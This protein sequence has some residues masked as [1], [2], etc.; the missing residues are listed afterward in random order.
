LGGAPTIS[1]EL[2]GVSTFHSVEA[3]HYLRHSRLGESSAY[4]ATCNYY[5]CKVINVNKG[6]NVTQHVNDACRCGYFEIGS[7]QLTRTYREGRI[8][9]LTMTLKKGACGCSDSCLKDLA[10]S[11]ISVRLDDVSHV[12]YTQRS[13]QPI[14]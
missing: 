5:I 13:R 10:V 12:H 11:M 6:T 9:C 4:H 2:T 3:W 7:D 8:P 1:T 14:G